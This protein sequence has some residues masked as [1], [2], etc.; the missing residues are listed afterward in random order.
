MAADR[1]LIAA[2]GK[3][4]PAKVDYSGYMKAIGAVGT[5][6]NTK[7]SIAQEYINDRPDGIDISEIPKEILENE[8]NQLFFE[9]S[10][11][12]YNKAVKVVRNQPAFT[13]KYR[14]AVKTMNDIKKGFEKVKSGLVQYA[15]YKKNNF[16]EFTNIS[17]QTNATDMDW[18]SSMV[19]NNSDGYIDSKVM[20]SNEGISFDGVDI[21]DFPSLKTNTIG[22]KAG[23][24]FNDIIKKST[25]RMEG[26]RKFDAIET[27]GDIER[28]IANLLANGNITAVKSLAFDAEFVDT[29]GVSKTFMQVIADEITIGQDDD[30]GK[31]YNGLTVSAAL[32]KY[33]NNMLE[34]G[35]V[36]SESAMNT[37][38]DAMLADVWNVDQNEKLTKKLTEHIYRLSDHAYHT[39]INYKSTRN[40]GEGSGK[41]LGGF[42]GNADNWNLEEPSYIGWKSPEELD[43]MVSNFNSKKEFI[44]WFGNTYVPT[45]D[46]PPSKRKGVNADIAQGERV[47][48]YKV[49]PKVGDGNPLKRKDSNNDMV[50]S[51]EQAY[52]GLLGK[53][54]SKKLP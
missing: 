9:N 4:G 39:A 28:G 50:L 5:Y 34:E 2:A 27:R 33:K 26:G 16:V 45:F 12:D 18:A 37:M 15:E 51:Y 41:I 24:F 38:R 1:T 48:S 53:Y 14:E 42:N 3:M 17:K 49:V 30:F 25:D 22:L 21:N 44:D 40:G 6:V 31:D 20:F 32:K 8:A 29:D 19:I 52:M 13:K 36:V 23:E 46:V 47:L 11:S 10:K 7:N 43:G 54:E 35:S